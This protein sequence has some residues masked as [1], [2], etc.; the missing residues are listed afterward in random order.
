M[1]EPTPSTTA[2]ALSAEERALVALRL[3]P[4]IGP[5]TVEHLLDRFGTAEAALAAP[6]DELTQVPHVGP[7]VGQALRK[8][9]ANGDVE[10]ELKLMAGR[11]VRLLRR[12]VSPYP[13]ALAPL[14]GAPSLLYL[15]GTLRETD[16][17]AIAIVGSRGSTGYGRRIAQ[18]MAHDLARAGF[19]I[20]SGLARGID[21]EAH[22][23]AL[24][25]G[26]RTIAVL[27]NGLARVYPPEHAELADAVAQSGALLSEAS[28]RMEPLSGMFPAR[29]RI[30]TG[31]S[32]A[33]VVVE[34]G[35]KSGALISARHAAEQGRDVFVIPGNVDSIASAGSLSLLR[36]GARLVRHADDVLEDL[37]ALSA[38]RR[39]EADDEAPP[40]DGPAAAV[41]AAL[42]EPL[43]I[44]D[45]CRRTEQPIAALSVVLTML[46]MD[47]RV[48]KLP[49]NVY[50][51]A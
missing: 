37:H 33:L 43:S 13:E 51:R 23:G 21:A 5:R 40:L 30:I 32:R 7:T 44:D 17:R 3:V 45:L 11:G 6:L 50:E 20:V 25:A 39:Q 9:W 12:G 1:V 38:P 22:R 15:R 49:G 4:G 2:V 24:E 35:D 10:A 34:A 18:R 42:V 41:W 29:N 46:E 48:R 26:G 36:H 14:A 19:T 8:A 47:G 27:A 16:E 28:M 31:M